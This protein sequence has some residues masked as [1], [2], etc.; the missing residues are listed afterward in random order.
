MLHSLFST[1][2]SPFSPFPKYCYLFYPASFAFFLL[3][4][5]PNCFFLHSLSVEPSILSVSPLS[6]PSNYCFLHY[7]LLLLHLCFS[8][9]RTPL[10]APCTHKLKLS[11]LHSRILDSCFLLA[12]L[13]RCSICRTYAPEFNS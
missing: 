10:P 6:T 9:C 1:F 11:V 7:P 2:S 8:C 13:F 5:F 12:I 4:T 3:S